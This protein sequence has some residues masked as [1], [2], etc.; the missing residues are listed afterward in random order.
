MFYSDMN[1]SL[2]L[3]EKLKFPN[4]EI[5]NKKIFSSLGPKYTLIDFW[6][7]SCKPCLEQI[8]VYKKIYTKYKND[9]FEIINIS[10]DRTEDISKWK[11]LI[12]EKELNWVHF[13][14][15]NGVLTR[16][17]S[18]NKYPTSFLLDSEGKIIKK[19]STPEELERFLKEN[20]Q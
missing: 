4:L 9:G 3:S 14:D 7:S 19:D 10:S 1:N 15:E 17:Y 6:F 8:P 16:H 18:I 5:Q 20:I 13:L 2:Q 11:K 12:T